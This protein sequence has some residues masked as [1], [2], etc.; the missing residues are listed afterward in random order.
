MGRMGR[1]GRGLTREEKRMETRSQRSWKRMMLERTMIKD[2]RRM[3]KAKNL[4]REKGGRKQNISQA[5]IIE[6]IDSHP[7]KRNMQNIDR[8][9]KVKVSTKNDTCPVIPDITPRRNWVSGIMI[10]M[11]SEW[12]NLIRYMG[13]GWGRRWKC[14][15]GDMGLMRG[16]VGMGRVM[17]KVGGM[18]RVKGMMVEDM[19]NMMMVVVG[20]IGNMVAIQM[21]VEEK[22]AGRGD[23]TK[24]KTCPPLMPEAKNFMPP[25]PLDMSTDHTSMRSTRVERIKSEVT[26]CQTPSHRITHLPTDKASLSAMESRHNRNPSLPLPTT[27]KF[28]LLSLGAY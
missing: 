12:G 21:E 7:P 11:L 18:A 28:Q 3:T 9:I 20:D 19:E 26:P 25:S 23:M 10:D 5:H 16:R 2:R 15:R 6:M 8:T 13:L 17:V 14:K 1:D 22:M 24:M 27:M 4:K